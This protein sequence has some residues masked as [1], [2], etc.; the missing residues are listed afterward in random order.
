MTTIHA[1]IHS[2][3]QISQYDMK[4]SLRHFTKLLVGACTSMKKMRNGDNV[5]WQFIPE[6]KTIDIAY[7]PQIKQ[8]K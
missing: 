3:T 8:T 1:P 7:S 4:R 6:S 2:A 5:T